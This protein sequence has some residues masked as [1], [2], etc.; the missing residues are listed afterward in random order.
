MIKLEKSI[1]FLVACLTLLMAEVANACTR[2]TYTGPDN[3]VVTGRS[4]DWV[5]DIK[6]ELW[7]FPAGITRTG[8]AGANSVKWT[9]KYGSVIASGYNLGMTDGINVKGLGVNLLYLATSDY[10]KPRAERKDL[11]VFIW[12]QYVLDNYASVAEAVKDLSQ[13]QFNMIAPTLPNGASPSVHLALADPSGDNA[14][15]EY[16][17]GKLVI[18]HDK[19]FKVMTNEPT[20]DKQ[21]VL[22]DYWENLKGVFLPGTDDPADRFVRTSYYLNAAPQTSDEQISVAA[23]FSIIRNISVP[24]SAKTSD[25]PNVASTLWR[26]VADLKHNVYYFES[27]DRPNVFWV[28]LS[29]LDLK[30]KA[31][32]KKL[33]LVNNEVYAGEVSK[34]FVQSKPF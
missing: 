10:G 11:S 25:R 26:S 24:F 1:I 19:K 28:E 29:K 5:E 8:S 16:V 6:T 13:D 2:F 27:S 9:S 12:L 7:V 30:A 15:L 18:H 3:T 32:I 14:I 33:P 23:V 31:P 20:Y 34:H 17:A 4:M 21:L 22:N